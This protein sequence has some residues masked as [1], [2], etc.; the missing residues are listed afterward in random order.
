MKNNIIY[1]SYDGILEPLGYSQVV[2]Y[3]KKLSIKYNITLI[4]YEKKKDLNFE[5]INRLSKELQANNID[6]HFLTYH[7]F[8]KIFSTL[9]DIFRGF[10]NSS[11]AIIADPV[12]LYSGNIDT[13][14]IDETT[15]ESTDPVIG[16]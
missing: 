1:V 8:P 15:T 6:W 12:L 2:C 10:L 13:F 16:Q 5:N 9:Y 11:N 4:S 7:S 14:Q 3:I